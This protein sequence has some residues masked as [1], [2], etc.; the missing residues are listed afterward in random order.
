MSK[1]FWLLAFVAVAVGVGFGFVGA[2]LE[3]SKR[4]GIGL[5]FVMASALFLCLAGIF[6]TTA[7]KFQAEGK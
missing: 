2:Y 5:Y 7:G 1:F 3:V 4:T 6:P